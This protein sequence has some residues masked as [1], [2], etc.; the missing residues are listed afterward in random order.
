MRAPIAAAMIVLLID[1]R[2]SLL[3]HAPAGGIF[4][5]LTPLRRNAT[6]EEKLLSR[7]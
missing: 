4:A 1:L 6:E 7:S 2:I 5:L 3:L